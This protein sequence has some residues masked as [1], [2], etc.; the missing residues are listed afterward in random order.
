MSSTNFAFLMNFTE[1]PQISIKGISVKPGEVAEVHCEIF[2]FPTS[3][4]AWAF[5]PCEKVEF[6][7]KSCDESKKITYAVSVTRS[8]GI[9]M[10]S[11]KQNNKRTIAARL[12]HL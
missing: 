5:T 1:K 3:T 2:G 4:V 7:R 9:C 12:L 6:D 8:I 10:K 11:T